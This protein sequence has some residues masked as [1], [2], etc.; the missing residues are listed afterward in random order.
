MRPTKEHRRAIER[1]VGGST[2]HLSQMVR[3]DRFTSTFRD[4]T[5]KCMDDGTVYEVVGTD[6]S[7]L[8][9]EVK[10]LTTG[11][12]R[13]WNLIEFKLVRFNCANGGRNAG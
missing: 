6:R 8:N 11:E 13:I 4:S 12:V 9:V 1:V 7:G 10:N 3:G 2:A 5:G